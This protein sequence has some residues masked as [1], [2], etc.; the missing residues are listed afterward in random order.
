MTHMHAATGFCSLLP[1]QS[2]YIK[3]TQHS[4]WY[5][6]NKFN[7]E[8]TFNVLAVLSG[9]TVGYIRYIDRYYHCTLP[10]IHSWRTACAA[11]SSSHIWYIFHALLFDK[12]FCGSIGC[13]WAYQRRHHITR[14]SPCVAWPNKASHDQIRCDA[15][16]RVC[17]IC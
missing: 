7:S 17:G 15:K 10:D 5:L 14:T 12:L 4:W 8:S 16:V 13:L 11:A 1:D 9:T 2:T 6:T 3:H